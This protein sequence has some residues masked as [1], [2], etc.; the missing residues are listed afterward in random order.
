MQLAEGEGFEPP[1]PFGPSA[2]EAVPFSHSGTLPYVLDCRGRPGATPA[3]LCARPARRR[4]LLPAHMHECM[5]TG[6]TLPDTASLAS[7]T[8]MRTATFAFMWH[9]MCPAP[10]SGRRPKGGKRRLA[11]RVRGPFLI[12]TSGHPAASASF[13]TRSAGGGNNKPGRSFH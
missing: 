9:Q 7:A 4:F 11:P 3:W 6:A 8:W 13:A 12:W 5:H 2:F 10:I 1:R